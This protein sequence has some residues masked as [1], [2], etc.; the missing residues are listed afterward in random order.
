LPWKS[1]GVTWISSRVEGSAGVEEVRDVDQHDRRVV[2]E[3]LLDVAANVGADE[4][5]VDEK[6]LGERAVGVRRVAHRQQVDDLDVRQLVAA[7]DERL[8]EHRRGAAAGADEDAVSGAQPAHRLGGGGDHVAVLLLPVR[9]EGTVLHAPVNS[10]A[11]RAAD[12]RV[13]A[14]GSVPASPTISGL[15]SSSAISGKSVASWLTRCSRAMARRPRRAA[16]RARTSA[17]RVAVSICSAS[18]R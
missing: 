11:G 18:R 2:P 9:V 15:M 4:E 14:I 7:L 8:D 12:A 16:A 6:A 1:G 3:S 13:G 10:R 5:A 17:E